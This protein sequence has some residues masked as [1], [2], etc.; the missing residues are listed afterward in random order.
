MAKKIIVIEDDRDILDIMNYIL[1]EEGYEVVAAVN[2]KP[3]EQVLEHQPVLILM[4][5]RLTDGFG[6]DFC[7]EF[8][9]NPET[10]HFPVVI[11]SANSGIEE[12]ARE[13]KADGY[14]KK[15]FDITELI[16]LVK[17][18]DRTQ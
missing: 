10:T 5:N 4:D 6:Q 11:V 1:S 7:R 8:K 2:C 14:L 16:D 15:P 13:S 17:K 3:L 9:S 12:I 18:F